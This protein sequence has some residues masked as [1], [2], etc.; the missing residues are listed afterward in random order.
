MV[1]TCCV[2]GCFSRG[3]RDNVSFHSIPCVIVHQGTKVRELSTKRLREWLAKINRK[4]WTPKKYSR[5]CSRHFI[6]GK[7]FA[8]LYSFKCTFCEGG[9]PAALHEENDP[10][11]IPTINMGYATDVADDARYSRLQQR[12]RKQSEHESEDRQPGNSLDTE[13]VGEVSSMDTEAVGEMETHEDVEVVET[14]ATHQK[15]N[16]Q[17]PQVSILEKK[18]LKELRKENTILRKEVEVLSKFY[19]EQNQSLE[20]KLKDDAKLLKFYTGKQNACVKMMFNI[21]LLHL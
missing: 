15:T 4:D 18:E 12:R 6:N 16:D 14:L 10:N 17:S 5:V 21:Y 2:L 8:M 7:S 3:K 13:A 11:W 9:R 1:L 20:N 19:I